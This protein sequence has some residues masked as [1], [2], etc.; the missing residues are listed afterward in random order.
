MNGN[1]TYFCASG[2]EPDFTSAHR[3]YFFEILFLNLYHA[4]RSFY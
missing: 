1:F 2:V 4:A 3:A